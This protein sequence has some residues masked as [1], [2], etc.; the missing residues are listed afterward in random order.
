MIRILFICTLITLSLQHAFA[1][2]WSSAADSAL[3]GLEIV[4]NDWKTS[5]YKWEGTN[6]LVRAVMKD[7][8]VF[9]DYNGTVHLTAK[10][11]GCV[12]VLPY[13]TQWYTFKKSNVGSQVFPGILF[14]KDWEVCT[15][16]VND[17]L[18]GLEARAQIQVSNR[19][20]TGS[21]TTSWT[22]VIT[23]PE[24]NT[25]VTADSI[26]LVWTTTKNKRVKIKL[27]W[28]TLTTISSD[29]T[30]LFTYKIK[31]LDPSSLIQA[32]LLD[33]NN[34]EV[35][36]S[37]VVNITVEWGWIRFDSITITEW[38]TVPS[39]AQL[40][41]TVLA[42]KALR[43]NGV[44]V[45]IVNDKGSVMESLVES[46]AEQGKYTGIIQAPK[47]AWT[48]PV[49]VILTNALGKVLTKTGQI[50]L[51]VVDTPVVVNTG[52]SG[53]VVPTSPAIF[54]NIQSKAE[55]SRANFTFTLD[56]PPS[57]LWKF[58]I[59]YGSSREVLNQEVITNALTWILVAGQTNT[60]AWFI[61]GF[62]NWKMYYK[63]LWL[64][65]ENGL[66]EWVASDIL[67]IDMSPN[68]P[69]KCVINNVSW[70]VVSTG[71]SK[72]TL[73]WDAVSNAT[74]YNI[75]KK[76]GNSLVLLENVKVNSY[77]VYFSNNLV[78]FDDFSVK[79]VCNDGTESSE[80]VSSRVQTGPEFLLAVLFLAGLIGMIL[81]Q[82]NRQRKLR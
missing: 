62:S 26:D 79:A 4:I 28:Q 72:S 6:I 52:S 31:N 56:N 19:D 24:N 38:T 15:V 18:N 43:K 44:S 5:V 14:E 51:Q 40:H 37:N 61:N 42:Q 71:S 39:G 63:I 80:Y 54:K 13:Q 55:G 32:I 46:T 2:T 60:Y 67:E 22:I 3:S 30:G 66:I 70:L 76:S 1:A 59:V 64:T 49:N 7:G 77:T 12:P 33:A 35:A 41:I 20:G 47:D 23:S 25:K 65:S 75:Y 17:R 74:S 21:T 53:S 36:N 68:A 27:N 81:M 10:P 34:A 48:Y 58:K 29:A 11:D 82:Y 50:Q 57:N 9:R 8:T 73:T 16:T 69:Q 45:V 78:T